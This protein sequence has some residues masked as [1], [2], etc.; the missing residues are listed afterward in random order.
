[1][2]KV[3]LSDFEAIVQNIRGYK[4]NLRIIHHNLF[5]TRL[6]RCKPI[7]VFIAIQSML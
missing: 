5:I 2:I 4:D 6:L 3:K 7:S 1:M